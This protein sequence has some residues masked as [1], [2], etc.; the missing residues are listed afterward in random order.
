MSRSAPLLVHVAGAACIRG[1]RVLLATRRRRWAVHVYPRHRRPREPLVSL[2]SARDW[3]RYRRQCPVHL[4]PRRRC[5]REALVLFLVGREWL[6]CRDPLRGCASVPGTM[7]RGSGAGS[8]P[9]GL[10][11]S[12]GVAREHATSVGSMTYS[13]RGI[14]ARRVSPLGKVLAGGMAS[15]RP[16]ARCVG[17]YGCLAI[18]SQEGIYRP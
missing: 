12:V 15:E 16:V 2:L 11:S 17:A 9:S 8:I 5:P 3:L 1:I 4:H 13:L 7:R 14:A 10:R 6:G 18:C